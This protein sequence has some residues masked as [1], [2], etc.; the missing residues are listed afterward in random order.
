MIC[1]IKRKILKTGAGHSS[2]S[3]N[4][5]SYQS[6]GGFFSSVVSIFTHLI[7]TKHVLL[8]PQF[9]KH[10]NRGIKIFNNLSA[11]A[12]IQTRTG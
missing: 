3:N 2:H 5:N 11:K 6:Q 9:Y 1:M 10:R 8:N 12:K 7:L 4:S